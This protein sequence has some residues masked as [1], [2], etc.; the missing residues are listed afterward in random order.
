MYTQL[1]KYTHS[2]VSGPSN[3]VLKLPRGVRNHSLPATARHNRT[4]GKTDVC[5]II[6]I[7]IIS[8]SIDIVL[9]IVIVIVI[10][11]AVAAIIQIICI[12]ISTSS[13]INIINGTINIISVII[14]TVVIAPPPFVIPYFL[15][16]GLSGAVASALTQPRNSHSFSVGVAKNSL[17]LSREWGNASL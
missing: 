15:A 3:K 2:P 1:F 7:V 5:I 9:V 10:V 11:T 16:A 14:I 6:I 8:S 12:N 4:T 17:V 13:P